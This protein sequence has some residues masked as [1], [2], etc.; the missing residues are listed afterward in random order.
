M[1]DVAREKYRR[2]MAEI[3]DLEDRVEDL[4]RDIQMM[5]ESPNP[6]DP[7]LLTEELRDL[8][9]ALAAKRNELARLSDGCGRPHPQA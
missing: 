6:R 9:E 4:K 3:A 1:T 2:L 8:Q 7:Q 5:Q